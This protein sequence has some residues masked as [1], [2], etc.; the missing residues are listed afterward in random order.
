MGMRDP[1]IHCGAVHSASSCFTKTSCCRKPGGCASQP[2]IAPKL[3][4]R[5]REIVRR[6]RAGET[7]EEL[8]RGIEVLVGDYVEPRMERT[9]DLAFTPFEVDVALRK[10]VQQLPKELN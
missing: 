6:F 7:I 4:G 3:T 5:E 10:A 8:T 2:V 1:C 9:R